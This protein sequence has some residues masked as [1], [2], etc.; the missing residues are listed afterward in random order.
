ML[1]F[2]TN[3]ESGELRGVI[4]YNTELFDRSRMARL[5][6]HFSSLLSAVVE[7]TEQP[8]AQLPLLSAD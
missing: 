5:A 4:E 3:R 7:D 2:S 8:L 1:V 6:Q